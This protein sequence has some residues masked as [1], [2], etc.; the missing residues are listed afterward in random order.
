MSTIPTHIEIDERSFNVA[1]LHQ[2]ILALGLELDES[3]IKEKQAGQDTLE[4]IRYLQE[5]FGIEF[6]P[7]LLVDTPTAIALEKL[8]QE[9]ELTAT[10]RSFTVSGSVS[11]SNGK[12]A[13]RQTLLAFDLD[14]RGVAVYRTVQELEELYQ[15]QGFEYLGSAISDSK[16]RYR[17][18]FYDWQYQ[19]AERNKADIV[20]YAVLDNR[21]LAHSRLVN[22][23]DYSDKGFVRG[24]DLLIQIRDQ[25]SEYAALMDELKIFLQENRSS[26]AEIAGSADLLAFTASELDVEAERINLVAAAFLLDK[27]VDKSLSHQILYGLG[28]RGIRLTWPAI[29]KQKA[30]ELSAAIVAA[31]KARIIEEL[32]NDQIQSFI[33]DLLEC[34]SIE[35]LRDRDDQHPNQLNQMLSNALPKQS[36]RVGFVRALN[37][38]IGSDFSKFWN[39]HLPAQPEFQQQ[40]ELIDALMLTQRLTL[41]SGHHQKLVTELQVNRQLSSITELLKF[42]KDDWQNL[43]AITG[44]PDSV[45]GDDELTR[46]NNYIEMMEKIL[47]D[48]FPTQRIALMLETGELNGVDQ[49]AIS[50][51][52]AFLTHHAEFDISRSRI[53]DFDTEIAEIAGQNFALVQSELL[54]LQRVFQ[55]SPTPAVMNTLLENKLTSARIISDYPKKNFIHQYSKPLGGEEVA[56]IVHKKASGKA[57]HIEQ[58]GMQ[59]YEYGNSPVPEKIISEEQKTEVDNTLENYVA[60]YTELFN[61]QSFCECEHCRSVFG[62]A[63]YLVDVLRFL[64]RTSRAPADSALAQL[65]RR[66]PDIVHL[67][68]TCENSNTLIPY[69]DLANE[70]LEAF[71]AQDGLIGFSGHDTGNTPEAELQASPQN[72][73]INAYRILSDNDTTKRVRFPFTLPY[74]QPLDVIRVYSEQLGISRYQVLKTAN[75]TPDAMT[76]RAIAAEALQFAPEEYRM[77]TGE[78]FDG[79]ADSVSIHHYFG[80]SNPADMASELPQVLE[81]LHRTGVTYIELVELVKTQFINPDQEQ[82]DFLEAVFAHGSLSAQTQYEKLE[83]IAAG[84]ASADDP[85]LEPII[86]SYSNDR[87]NGMTHAQFDEWVRSNFASVRE[88]ITLYAPNSVC[89]LAQTV[90]STIARVYATATSPGLPADSP[91]WPKFHTFIRLWRKLDWSIHELDLVLTALDVAKIDANTISQ[92]EALTHLLKESIRPVNELAVL[93]GNIDSYGDRS[94]YR[95]LFLSISPQHVDAAFQADAWGH[96]LTDTSALLSEH[97]LAILAAFRI[98][99]PELD[100][101]LT[102]ASVIDADTRRLLDLQTDR[103]NLENLSTIFRYVVLARALKFKIPELIQLLTIYEQLPTAASP[104]ST[105]QIPSATAPGQYVEIDPDASLRFY[106]FAKSTREAGFTP[107]RL[108]YIVN[109]VLANDSSLALEHTTIHSVARAIRESIESIEQSH[110]TEPEAPLTLEALSAKLALVFPQLSVQKLV[111]I[112]DGTVTFEA[113]ADAGLT[114]DIPAELADRYAYSAGSGRVTASGI[115]TGSDLSVLQGLTT[116]T[117]F[118]AAV[119]ELYTAPEKMLSNDFG[120]L[121]ADLAEA[122]GILLNHP[123]QPTAST[124][125][126][127]LEYLYDHFL[128]ILTSKLRRDTVTTHLATLLELSEQAIALLLGTE[129]DSLAERLLDQG[130]S[131]VYYTDHS[132]TNVALVRTDPAIDFRWDASSPD[133]LVPTDN[134]SVRWQAYVLPPTGGSYTLAV[135]VTEADEAFKLFLDGKLILEKTAGDSSVFLEQPVSLNAAEFHIV[136]L[137]YAEITGNAG[138]RLYWQNEAGVRQIIA[139]NQIFPTSIIDGFTTRVIQLHRADLLITGFSLQD[140]ALKHF[141]QYRSD[142]DGIDFNTPS[143]PHWI[144]LRDYTRLRDAIPQVQSSL[145]DVFELAQNN[146]PVLTVDAL[147]E[148]LRLATQWDESS[149]KFLVNDHFAL[150]IAD[151]RNE[152]ALM[153]L[154]RILKLGRKT[155]LSAQTIIDWGEATTDFD[156]LDGIAQ[157]AKDA[158]R[159]QYSEKD[160][161]ELAA[162]LNDPL[163]EHQQAALVSYLLQH[164]EIKAELARLGITP[165]ADGLFE[166]LLIDVQM[167]ACM[168]TSRIVQASAAIQMFVNRILLNLEKDISPEVI[169]KERWEWMS[170]YRVWEANRK[171]FVYPENWLAPEWRLDRSEFFKTLESYL[172][173]NDITER[174]VEQAFRDYLTSL[175]EVSNLDVCGMHREEAEG[176]IG[177]RLHVFGRTHSVPYRYFYRT[178][179]EFQKWSAWESVP[180]DIKSVEDGENSGVH[181]LPVVWKKRL[182]L[183]WPEFIDVHVAPEESASGSLESLAGESVG[184]LAAETKSEIRLAWSEYVDGKWATKQLTKEFFSLTLP[185]SEYPKKFFF[186]EPHFNSKNLDI[187]VMFLFWGG[188]FTPGHFTIS[189]LHSS[190]SMARFE[191]NKSFVLKD[192]YLPLFAKLSSGGMLPLNFNNATYLRGATN[193]NLVFGNTNKRYINSSNDINFISNRDQGNFFFSDT[194]RTYFVRP[195]SILI[196]DSL[197]S[198]DQQNLP[199]PF[200]IGSDG[201]EGASVLS[202]GIRRAFRIRMFS[203]LEFHTFH[204]PYSS[205][206]VER[207]NQGGL[208]TLMDSDTV[209][210]SDQYFDFISGRKSFFEVTYKPTVDGGHVAKP[211]DFDTRTYYKQNVCFDVYGANSLYN[212]ELFFHAPLYI[213]IRLSRNGKYREAMQWFHFIFDPQSEKTPDETESAR[214]WQVLPFKTEPATR[215]EEWFKTLM[216][217]PNPD[218]ENPIIAEW[219]ENPFDPHLVASNRPIAYMKHVLIEYIKNLLAWGDAKF[220]EFTRESVYEALQLYVIARHTLGKRPEQV[221]KRG[222]IGSETYNTLKDKLDDF[223]NALVEL[224]N[225]FPYSGSA[226]STAPNAGA[227]LLG[228]GSALYFCIPPNEKI[229]E[230]WETV[231]DR[232]FK[233]RHCQDIKGAERQLALFAPPID[234]AALIQARAQGLSLGSILAD[235]SSPPPIYRFSFLLQKANEFCNDVKALG[236]ALLS[237]LEKHDAEELSRLRAAQETQILELVTGI[238]ARQVLDARVNKENLLK[239]RET[240]LLRLQHYIDLLGNESVTIPAEPSIDAALAADSELPA[241]TSIQEI[242][243]DVDETLVDSDERG[244]KLIPKEQ[245]DLEKRNFSLDLQKIAAGLD[246]IVGLQGLL[247]NISANAQPIGVGVS[248]SFGGSNLAAALSAVARNLHSRA[249]QESSEAAIASTTASYIRRDQDW[250]FQ[251]N[252]AAREIIQLDKQIT[253][254]DIRLQMAEKELENHRKQIENSKQVERFLQD[255]FTNLELYQW[256]KEQLLSVYKQS[257]NLAFDLAKRA[258]QAYQYEMGLATASF[259]QYGYWSDAL[260]GLAA[261]EKLQLALRQMETAYLSENRRELE[262]RKNISLALLDPV[263]LIQLRETGKCRISL[264]EEL[265]DLDFQ[266]HY[267]RRLKTLSLSLPCVVGP[268]TTVSCTLRLINHTTRINTHVSSKGY[269]H[270]NDEG[271]W[272]DDNRFRTVLTPVTSISTSTALND[273]GLFE[274]SFRD[275]RYLPFE[276]AGAIS[277]WEIQLTEDPSLRQFDYSTI[278]DVILHLSYTARESG[279]PFT[280]KVTA[281]LSGFLKNSDERMAQPFMRLFSAKHEFSNQWNRF[282]YPAVTASNQILALELSSERFPFLFKNKAIKIQRVDILLKLK[283]D[284]DSADGA[285]IQ[286]EL[287]HSTST[288]SFILNPSDK[289]G[290]LL[291]SGQEVASSLGGWAF[292]VA[293]IPSALASEDNLN[294]LNPEAIEDL[295]VVVHY[296]VVVG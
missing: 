51:L 18:I 190:M 108:D 224:E 237:A 291:H 269:E 232:L 17:I 92:M 204:H 33:K 75:P 268:Y 189:D 142:F 95:K 56:E 94:L 278:S 70:V 7:D 72:F 281:H 52:N 4:R 212:W 6:N 169:D 182:I 152:I 292:E 196:S 198:S 15:N 66:R 140:K 116:D 49:T 193:H 253:S 166:Y 236:S 98:T 16:G 218:N 267:F 124:F 63:A 258:E 180:V 254:A 174:N 106:Q 206:F 165:D 210:P 35:L 211:E 77:L 194:S 39:E 85:Q 285:G 272:I 191:P 21:I 104:F 270:L 277:E 19:K 78:A 290:G 109:G 67:P 27:S 65:E 264:P 217:N 171:V 187:Y 153:P 262:L 159:A 240:A 247:P 28:R 58:I 231:E 88:I 164:P 286:F 177:Y 155:G 59:L 36:Q 214:V 105:W 8:L 215:L 168:D 284:S 219:R 121:F 131:A 283:D 76:R 241:D 20:V 50:S 197:S 294:R 133:S 14:L 62:P 274:F 145:I 181:L 81:F 213:A 288:T 265:F 141:I 118:Q 228:M 289:F 11:F 238:R 143:L 188:I 249:N 287:T 203:Q 60:N 296:S 3:E 61:E 24:I 205:T 282:L 275:E 150:S 126:E 2:A 160:W 110:S 183:F 74:H 138:V 48:A 43:V 273:P 256:M 82:L 130:F 69:I 107:E 42:S 200:Q 260:Q 157:R 123:A 234:P 119:S 266:N 229:L 176:G 97:K 185:L 47:N 151:F 144:R 167:T 122:N 101:I 235:L 102:V 192:D 89:D 178:W 53:Y 38:F 34:T 22:A 202:D 162:S 137:D 216:P 279:G 129:I 87:A 96:Y 9:R 184:A 40:P 83:A 113:Y 23:A 239:A 128:P 68:L 136:Q 248:A 80:Y 209:L 207:L 44:I 147:T 149:L 31:A 252:L 71:T 117:S 111:Q 115:M 64:S 250:T 161:L 276:G 154:Y 55:I 112:L 99:E 79:T 148:R 259:I 195:I 25:R 46:A 125:D 127:K 221:P 208:Q 295:F 263:A 255:K 93:W 222:R 134:F 246:D 10:R 84:A 146:D 54:T 139:G 251:A 170:N 271:I 91:A 225:I 37:S 103:L 179:N 13:K 233:I 223:G 244:V 163:R 173:Q 280:D 227:S 120:G 175:N 114:I 30:S 199:T 45:Q 156:R 293:N 26:L 201:W 245:E 90:L 1:L 243:T 5:R 41:L 186:F 257:Y 135:E 57:A 261:G 12:A 132:W 32:S 230:C 29:F 242:E 100:A 73:S 172:T 158:V 86:R 220:R 226:S